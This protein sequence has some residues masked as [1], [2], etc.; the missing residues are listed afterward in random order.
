[1][2]LH[3]ARINAYPTG[4]ANHR[5]GRKKSGFARVQKYSR[6]RPV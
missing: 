3:T 1:V 4:I 2:S 6:N 5:S